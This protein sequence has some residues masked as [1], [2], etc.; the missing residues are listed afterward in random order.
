MFQNVKRRVPFLLLPSCDLSSPQASSRGSQTPQKVQGRR[1]LIHSSLSLI[2]VCGPVLLRLAHLL[3]QPL[4]QARPLVP[5]KFRLHVEVLGAE[6]RA[7]APAEAETD[8]AAATW[9]SV[10]E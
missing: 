2:H 8:A 5:G 3:P 9:E 1:N 6:G 7:E 4:E 10:S